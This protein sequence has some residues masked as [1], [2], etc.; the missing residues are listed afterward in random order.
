MRVCPARWVSLQATRLSSLSTSPRSWAAKEAV[1]KAVGGFRLLFP[2]IE[3]VPAS[4]GAQLGPRPGATLPSLPLAGSGPE[5]RLH[6]ETL[7]AARA[8]GVGRVMLSISHD[9]DTA[10]AIALAIEAEPR[11]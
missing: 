2:E 6:G 8:M 7:V 10:M 3:V 4:K 11:R 1:Y 5:V 9:G